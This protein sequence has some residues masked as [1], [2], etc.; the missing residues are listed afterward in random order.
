M[1][2][3]SPPVTLLMHSPHSN[4]PALEQV[5]PKLLSVSAIDSNSLVHYAFRL[6]SLLRSVPPQLPHTDL[7]TCRHWIRHHFYMVVVCHLLTLR[8]S[9]TQFGIMVDCEIQRNL[10]SFLFLIKWVVSLISILSCTNPMMYFFEWIF[11]LLYFG[12]QS[13]R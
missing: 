13:I 9:S 12:I 7:S 11:L 10:F 1:L 4:L 8:T 3:K 6:L 2:G 5:T